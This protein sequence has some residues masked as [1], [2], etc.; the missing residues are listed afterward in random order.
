VSAGEAR[1]KRLCCLSENVFSLCE[2]VFSLRAEGVGRQAHQANMFSW[3]T[4]RPIH[5]FAAK[6]SAISPTG[7][8][9][10]FTRRGFAQRKRPG[11]QQEKEEQ[12]RGERGLTWKTARESGCALPPLRRTCFSLALLY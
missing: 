4:C 8:G 5:S 10:V 1:E 3:S 6:L 9:D 7:L 2:N 11:E 12:G